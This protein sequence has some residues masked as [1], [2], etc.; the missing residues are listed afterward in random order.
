M[1]LRKGYMC[2]Y[3]ALQILA[4]IVIFCSLPADVLWGSFVTEMNT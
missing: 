4:E 3:L 2:K 1:R